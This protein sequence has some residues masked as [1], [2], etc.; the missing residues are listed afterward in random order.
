TAMAGASDLSHLFAVDVL[1]PPTVNSAPSCT[2]TASSG[3]ISL[4][5]TVSLSAVVQDDESPASAL[6]VQWGLV[7]R[8]GAQPVLVPTGGLLANDAQGAAF[9]PTAAGS[10]ELGCVASDGTLSGAIGVTSVSVLL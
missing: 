6:S 4:G 2:P 5:D 8:S 7:D 1:Q 9:A 3:L 10:F